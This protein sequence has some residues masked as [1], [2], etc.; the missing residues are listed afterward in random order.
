MKAESKNQNKN[1]MLSHIFNLRLQKK[2]C[3]L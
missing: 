1:K 2:T 3:V